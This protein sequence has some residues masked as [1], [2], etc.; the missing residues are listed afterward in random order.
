[1]AK[2]TFL[3]TRCPVCAS[4][5]KLGTSYTVCQPHQ[6]TPPVDPRRPWEIQCP[7]CQTINQEDYKFCKICKH[8]LEKTSVLPDQNPTIS[9]SSPETLVAPLT[10][11]IIQYGGASLSP[12][13]PGMPRHDIDNNKVLLLELPLTLQEG[14]V[15]TW[16]MGQRQGRIQIKPMQKDIHVPTEVKC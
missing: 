13:N 16:I 10:S 9:A 8:P 1:M 4:P 15:L 3:G 11:I 14:E 7:H 5:L 12:T 2:P 6:S